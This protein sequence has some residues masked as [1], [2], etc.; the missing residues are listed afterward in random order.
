MNNFLSLNVFA[1]YAELFIFAFLV[2]F[3]MCTLIFKERYKNFFYNS[4]LLGIFIGRSQSAN[5]ST[6]VGFINTALIQTSGHLR[7]TLT[8]HPKN[9]RNLNHLQS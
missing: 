3:L 9:G 1:A 5:P 7:P 2:T 4:V 6:T 8:G